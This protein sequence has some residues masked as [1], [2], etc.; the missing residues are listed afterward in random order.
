MNQIWMR[1]DIRK[2]TVKIEEKCVIVGS[3]IQWAIDEVSSFRH[4]SLYHD[5]WI[6]ISPLYRLGRADSCQ[7]CDLSYVHRG[8]RKSLAVNESS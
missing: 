2:R 5:Y 1:G 8:C 4:K 6:G 7:V 3:R